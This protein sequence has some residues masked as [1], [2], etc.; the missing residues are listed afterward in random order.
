MPA[1]KDESKY[2]VTGYTGKFVAKLDSKNRL[3]IPA[4]LRKTHLPS[5]SRSKKEKNRFMLTRGLDGGLTL[6]PIT[7]WKRIEERLSEIPFTHRDF[8]HFTR[9]LYSEA[10]EVVLDSQGRIPISKD[11]KDLVGLRH[12]TLIIGVGRWI[13]IWNPD[14]YQGYIGGVG[15]SYETAAEQLFP[16][17]NEAESAH[18]GAGR[19]GA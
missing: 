13:E 3:T 14:R 17:N 4:S 12:E 9:I 5:K 15:I 7:E 10:A 11:H 6:F 1:Q 19:K 18:T 16:G 8:R 2:L